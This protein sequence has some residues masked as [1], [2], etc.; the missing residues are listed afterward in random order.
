MR[1]RVST[2]DE[3]PGGSGVFQ[4]TFFSAPNSL[5][6]LVEVESPEPFGPRKRDQSSSATTLVVTLIGANRQQTKPRLRRNVEKKRLGLLLGAQAALPAGRGVARLA[7][8]LF[9]SPRLAGKDACAPRECPAALRIF[10][11]SS[12][13]LPVSL[14][15]RLYLSRPMLA[16]S[17][18]R[19]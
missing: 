5:G 15:T 18:P 7:E 4:T 2:G 8:F 6:R 12:V 17:G 19:A 10:M 13:K 11:N 16:N 9:F 3:W 1:V 14:P